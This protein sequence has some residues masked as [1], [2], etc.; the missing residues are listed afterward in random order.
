MC[1]AA[2][3]K[4]TAGRLLPP[5]VRNCLAVAAGAKSRFGAGRQGRDW[6]VGGVVPEVSRA[7]GDC[8]VDRVALV[9]Q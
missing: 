9:Q 4:R 5:H 8:G 3:G 6:P 2:G 1:P 7:P